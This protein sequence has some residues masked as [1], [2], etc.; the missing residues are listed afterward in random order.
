MAVS[1][2]PPT[3]KRKQ[4]NP[5]FEANPVEVRETITSIKKNEL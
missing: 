1:V 3:R 4:D 5:E 2:L